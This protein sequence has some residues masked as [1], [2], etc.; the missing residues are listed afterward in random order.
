MVSSF[1]HRIDEPFTSEHPMDRRSLLHSSA[2]ALY[3]RRDGFTLDSTV[4]IRSKNADEGAGTVRVREVLEWLLTGGGK[5]SLS[6]E[7]LNIYPDLK[8]MAERMLG[9]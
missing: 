8:L 4:N 7:P 1:E 2:L 3:Q 5:Q 9:K 6:K